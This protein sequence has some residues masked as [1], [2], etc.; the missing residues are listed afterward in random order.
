M[1]IRGFSTDFH[2]VLRRNHPFGY[3]S[4]DYHSHHSLHETA[5]KHRK[6]PQ[7]AVIPA[8]VT[9]GAQIGYV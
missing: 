1:G 2:D 7:N 4:R 8:D 9:E 3:A 6:R 5:P